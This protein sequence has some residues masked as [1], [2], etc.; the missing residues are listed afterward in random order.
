M[1]HQFGRSRENIRYCVMWK[2]IV[3]TL[4]A[5]PNAKA[6]DEIRIAVMDFYIQKTYQNRYHTIGACC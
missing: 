1:R 4:G 2:P 3:L 6:I 5:L